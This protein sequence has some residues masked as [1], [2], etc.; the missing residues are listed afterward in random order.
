MGKPTLLATEIKKIKHLRETGH[1]LN[2]IK[3]VVNRGYGTVFRYIKDVPILPKYQEIWKIKRGGSKSKSLKEWQTARMQASE[4]FSS[5][6]FKFV[7]KKFKKQYLT[8]VIKDDRC[9]FISISKFH[10]VR[11][12]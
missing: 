5:F 12:K 2:E 9:F 8:I 11:S 10:F 4:I 7:M 1:S 6:N 3:N